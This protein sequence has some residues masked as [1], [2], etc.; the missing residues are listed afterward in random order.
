VQRKE[1][2]LQAERDSKIAELNTA[3]EE[4]VDS[5]GDDYA[6]RGLYNSGMRK[7]EQGRAEIARNS[8]LERIENEY[9]QKLSELRNEGCNI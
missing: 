5:I 9:Q 8:S 6:R 3:N 1:K 7:S 2:T 4:F